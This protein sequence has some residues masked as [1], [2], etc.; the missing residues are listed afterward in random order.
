LGI[1]PP[2]RKKNKSL[3]PKEKEVMAR[4]PLFL[5]EFFSK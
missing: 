2:G 3:N 4:A 5:N 1:Y